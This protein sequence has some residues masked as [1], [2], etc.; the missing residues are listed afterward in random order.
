MTEEINLKEIERKAWSSYF[1]DGLWDVFFGALFLIGGIRSLT[2]NVWYTLLLL[3]PILMLPIGKKLITI[4]R[5]GHVKFGPV[6]KLKQAKVIAVL[7]IS[8]LA[9]LVLWLLPHS[10]LSLPELSIS[11]ILAG[12]IA[13]VFGMIA[14]YLDFRR[15]FAYGLLYA[16]SEVLWGEF[17]EPI[18]PVVQTISGIVILLVGMAVFMRFVRRYPI[19]SEATPDVHS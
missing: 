7:A 8:V 4:P 1:E 11:P 10:G 2:N 13:V 12:W 18:G 16:L 9:T 6:R 5:L 19:L 14:Y 3:V 17:G 15:L